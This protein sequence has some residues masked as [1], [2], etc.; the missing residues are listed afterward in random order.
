MPK[1]SAVLLSL[2]LL[3]VGACGTTSPPV[4]RTDVERGTALPPPGLNT[5]AAATAR[6]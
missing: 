4:S 6:R 3:A 1:G 5:A 2:V